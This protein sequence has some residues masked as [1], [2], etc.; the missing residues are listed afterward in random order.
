MPESYSE[1]LRAIVQAAMDAG[2]SK[3]A[4]AIESGYNRARFIQWTN[5]SSINMTIES[6]DK[7]KAACKVLMETVS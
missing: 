7:I 2:V 5:D 6:A 1:E 3:S 4:I